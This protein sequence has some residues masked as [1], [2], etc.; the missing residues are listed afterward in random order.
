MACTVLI[1]FRACRFFGSAMRLWNCYV[2]YGIIIKVQIHFWK[3]AVRMELLKHWKVH[4]FALCIVIIAE[5]IGVHSFGLVVFLPLLYA[6]IMGGILSYPSFG[7]M[8]EKMMDVAGKVMPVIML[9]LI[10][11]IGLGI[12]PNL[13]MLLNSGWALIMQELGHFF[14][15]IVFG[16]PMALLLKMGR[17]AIGACYSI[18]REPNVAI[19]AEKYGIFSPEGRGVMGMYICGTL[20]GALWIS[21]LSGVIAR[22]GI[23]HPYA[24]AMGGGIGSASMMAA[25]IGSLVAVFPEEAQRIQAYAGA[26]NLMTTILGIYF[27]L[28][29]SLPV[30]VKVYEMVTGD[31]R[32]IH[33]AE[34]VQE[35]N[36]VADSVPKA[37]EKQ[38]FGEM[39]RD[40]VIILLIGG[41]FGAL[42]N[43]IGF[44]GTV[45]ESV[46][47][48][49]IFIVL[50]IIGI[51]L[52]HIPGLNKL[53]VVF[54]VSIVAIIVS[55]PG[56]PGQEWVVAET[57]KF[58]VLASTTP[59][60]AYAGLSLG[61]DIPAFK[62][63]SWRIVPVALMVATG[64]FLGATIM[65][66]I[67]LHLEGIF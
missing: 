29:I 24:L 62:R 36:A 51:V 10:V 52:A 38:P 2:K 67:V 37:A 20:F 35:E 39:M 22:T 31:K 25:S 50:S 46:F 64:S 56:F 27:A 33:V 47:S 60:L 65:A 53:P 13:H 11:K 6:L 42:G 18:D 28:F 49:I 21:I 40:A 63:L 4:V 14:G 15:T 58:S 26:A 5:L 3:G 9:L 57:N 66:E 8:N 43:C 32:S 12:G 55:I 19:I 16:L 41:I 23:F 1:A 7:I 48:S 44:D 59:I 30:T 17:E 45:G 34:T 54:W 61:K